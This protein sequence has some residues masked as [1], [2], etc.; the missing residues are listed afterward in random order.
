MFLFCFSAVKCQKP[1][2]IQNGI[3]EPLKDV[4]DYGEAVAYSC[5]K[6]YTLVGESIIGCPDNGAFPPPPQCLSELCRTKCFV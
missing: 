1:S 2:D 5:S 4:Y 6:D 3:F